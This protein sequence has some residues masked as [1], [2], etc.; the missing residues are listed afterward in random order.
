MHVLSDIYLFQRLFDSHFSLRNKQAYL[1]IILI[2]YEE[3][4]ILLIKNLF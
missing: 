2:N 1:A 3:K 4:L